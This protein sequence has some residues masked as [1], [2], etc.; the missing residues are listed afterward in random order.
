MDK[1]EVAFITTVVV[2]F[3][4]LGLAIHKEYINYNANMEECLKDHK[5]YECVSML[6]TNSYITHIGR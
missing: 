6:R 4:V 5:K 3:T 2:L 1:F